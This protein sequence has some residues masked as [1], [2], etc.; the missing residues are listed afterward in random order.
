MGFGDAVAI[1]FRKF[2]AFG[3][4]AERPEF[5]YWVLFYVLAN[6]VLT[7]VDMIVVGISTG[8]FSTFITLALLPPTI[9]ALAR[10]LHDSDRSAWWILLPIAPIP[11]LAMTASPILAVIAVATIL[12]S[13]VVVLLMAAA[14]GTAGPNRFGPESAA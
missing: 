12:V 10:R 1:C 9:A 11:M 7:V 2:F 3:G 4:R 14:P 13:F 8:P 6:M 5:W